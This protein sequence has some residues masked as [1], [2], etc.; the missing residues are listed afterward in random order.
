MRVFIEYWVRVNE[1][2]FV[3]MDP[4]EI[5]QMIEAGYALDIRINPVR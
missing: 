2:T 1:T 4:R 5:A 3:E